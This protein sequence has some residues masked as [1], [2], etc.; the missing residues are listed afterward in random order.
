MRTERRQIDVKTGIKI[1]RRQ[2][3]LKTGIKI[4]RRQIDLETGMRTERRQIDLKTGIKI[5]RRQ[6]DL[7]TG[8]KIE[9]RQIDLKTGMRIES[10][11]DTLK[12]SGGVGGDE[13]PDWS[14]VGVSRKVFARNSQFEGTFAREVGAFFPLSR[15]RVMFKCWREITASVVPLHPKRV[16][17]PVDHCPSITP[18]PPFVS[19]LLPPSKYPIANLYSWQRGR[20]ALVILRR[21]EGPWPAVTI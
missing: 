12:S 21:Y 1:E 19:P 20:T 4:E 2:I 18:Q 11:N 13:S 8:I 14:A 9:R 15:R 3:D 16:R 5:E 10:K 6:I 7:K 17:V